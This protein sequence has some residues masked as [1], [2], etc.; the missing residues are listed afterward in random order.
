METRSHQRLFD[1]WKTLFA[2]NES[3]RFVYLLEFSTFTR[4]SLKLSIFFKQQKLQKQIIIFMKILWK[5]DFSSVFLWGLFWGE[6]SSCIVNG[7]SL[8]P[9]VPC[10]SNRP[11]VPGNW[12][13]F[14]QEM[15]EIKQ[16]FPILFVRIYICQ[17][18]KRWW[19]FIFHLL[20]TRVSNCEMFFKNL[21]Q[22]NCF[23]F[24]LL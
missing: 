20:S 21:K 13:L 8:L 12:I 10:Q 22:K 9:P 4:L 11:S 15:N 7:V 17:D 14:K 2:E 5:W 23:W 16:I 6:I 1:W 19:S 3:N 18:N 24:F